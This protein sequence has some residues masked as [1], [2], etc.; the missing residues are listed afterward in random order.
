MVLNWHDGLLICSDCFLLYGNCFRLNLLLDSWTWDKFY[1]HKML[2]NVS[3]III[4]NSKKKKKF[5]HIF[6]RFNHNSLSYP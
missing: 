5:E 2:G 4:N 3:L 6:L 1:I